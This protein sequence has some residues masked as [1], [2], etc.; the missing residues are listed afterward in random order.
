MRTLET[1]TFMDEYQKYWTKR[2]DEDREEHVPSH[3]RL[4]T[5]ALNTHV[6]ALLVQRISR[7]SPSVRSPTT[8]RWI[9]FVPAQIELAW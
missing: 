3:H 7:G 9:S 8:F 4:N 6:A 1:L 2:E 5:H